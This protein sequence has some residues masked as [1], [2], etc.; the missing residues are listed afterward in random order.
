MDT[1]RLANLVRCKR[2][3]RGLRETAAEIANVSTSTLSR[4]ENYSLP[5]ME[6]FIAL[7]NWLKVPPGQLF[8]TKQQQQQLNTAEKIALLLLSDKRLE[9]ATADALARII[10]AAYR[11][12]CNNS[13]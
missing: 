3:N 13:H 8:V 9:P 10:K 4:V 11:D 5:D 7:C 12:L 1:E 2:G 6:T